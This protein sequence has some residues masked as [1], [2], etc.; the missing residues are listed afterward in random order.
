MSGSFPVPLPDNYCTVPKALESFIDKRYL[1]V[2]I[3]IL[4]QGV[5]VYPPKAH[6]LPY[7]GDS[8]CFLITSRNLAMEYFIQ[9]EGG[10]TIDRFG[11]TETFI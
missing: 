11:L 6:G 4:P 2:N 5:S 7:D 9:R 10:I 8:I 1:K 3:K